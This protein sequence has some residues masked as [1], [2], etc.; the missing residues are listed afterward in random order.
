MRSRRPFEQ[1]VLGS[2]PDDATHAAS[3]SDMIEELFP[4][5][6]RGAGR[7]G[8]GIIS[9]QSAQRLRF[10]SVQRLNSAA[11]TRTRVARGRAEYPNQLDYGGIVFSA[12]WISP[13]RIRQCMRRVGENHAPRIESTLGF[14]KAQLFSHWATAG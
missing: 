3:A 11:G 4:G 12:N 1:K 14:W 10:A 7:S 13:G 8:G 9:S 6:A 2:N 5:G